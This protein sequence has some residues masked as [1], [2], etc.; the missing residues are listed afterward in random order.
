[1]GGAV[2]VKPQEFRQLSGLFARYGVDEF[3][4]FTSSLVTILDRDG[5]FLAWN[6]SMEKLKRNLPQAVRVQDFLSAPSQ[7]LFDEFMKKTLQERM[8][9][10]ASLE[11]SFENRWGDFSCLFIPLPEERVLLIGE[12]LHNISD[13]AMISA[14]L[15]KIK[16]SLAIKETELRAVIAQADEV[17]HTDALTFLPNRRSI[18][19]DLQRE[20]TFSDRYGTPLAI[21]MVDIDH[22]KQIND[23]HGHVAGDEVLRKLAMELRNHI[24]H[25]DVIGRYGGEEFLVVLP[26]STIKAAAEQA[27][28]LCNYV[29]S[30]VIPSGENEIRITVSMGL[31]QYRIHREDWQSFLS[32]ADIALYQAKNAG[33]NRWVIAEE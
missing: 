32:R 16:R 15:E 20:V 10:Q 27:E 8:R 14:E 25:P 29:Q 7:V 26:H 9:K 30:L 2:P 17:S 3:L 22:F 11:F 4:E 31:A 6:L 24:R 13:L 19:G 5:S 1:L 18:L 12:P 21:S 28:R 33:R 23:T